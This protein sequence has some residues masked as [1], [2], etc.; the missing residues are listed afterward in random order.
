MGSRLRAIADDLRRGR[1]IDVYLTLAA[2]LVFGVLG[3]FGVSSFRWVGSVLLLCLIPLFALLLSI[4]DQIS[5]SA[6]QGPVPTMEFPPE[7]LA[8][9]WSS[10]T[11]ILLVG[12]TLFRTIRSHNNDLRRR[13]QRN[14]SVRV[15]IVDP[16][17]AMAMFLTDD[18]RQNGPGNAINNAKEAELALD[19]LRN[20]AAAHPGAAL[21]V[22]TIKHPI[23]LG[24]IFF[25]PSGPN[26][27]LY[28]ETYP[29]R[30]PE[31]HPH[32]VVTVLDGHWFDHFKLELE[33]M[34]KA[35]RA[36]IP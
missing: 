21:E 3:L 30:T 23:G 8:A 17:D 13:L 27:R 11:D 4:N 2:A 35:G 34:W 18:R 1:N 29:F 9:D 22:R 25:S 26:S 31:N 14:S 5:Q 36:V 33:N 6:R 12:V 15:P 32:F 28:A 16:T 19:D 20:V 7:P 24:G 10:D